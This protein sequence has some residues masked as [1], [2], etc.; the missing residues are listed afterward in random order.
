MTNRLV[1]EYAPDIVTPPGETLAEMLEE[2]GMSQAELAKRTGR[3]MKTINEI[4]KG[5]TALT[6][7]TALQLERVFGVPASFWN[8]REQLYR[9][10]LALRAE[11]F[12]GRASRLVKP[13]PD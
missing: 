9:E 6:P 1:N 10:N 8:N 13:I 11:Q 4:I 7:A 5:K 2:R 12:A 3:P